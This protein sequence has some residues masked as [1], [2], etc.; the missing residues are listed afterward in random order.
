VL[1]RLLADATLV[2]HLAFIVFVVAG[3][4][5]AL[6]W[7]RAPWLHLPAALWGVWIELSG[8]ICPLTPLENALRR[9]AGS[10][11]YQGGF[12]E[13]YLLPVVYPAGLSP[14][15]QLALAAAVVLA[16]AAVYGFVWRRRAERRAGGRQPPPSGV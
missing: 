14:R 1:A 10:S 4:L 11:G 3:G 5:L 15:V 6:R 2:L 12:V 13:H 8:G 9:A 7:R 16:N